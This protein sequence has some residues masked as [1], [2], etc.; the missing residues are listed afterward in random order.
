MQAVFYIIALCV[1][2]ANLVSD[3]L[4]GVIDPRIKY[5]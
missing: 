5:E 4:Y 3:I 1:I 2:G